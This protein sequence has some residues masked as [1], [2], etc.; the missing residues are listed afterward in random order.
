MATRIPTLFPLANPRLAPFSTTLT[1]GYL[2]RI[3]SMEPSVEPL[4]DTI[5]SH[6]TVLLSWTSESKQSVMTF[7][8]FQ[9]MITMDSF[10]ASDRALDARLG[11]YKVQGFTNYFPPVDRE[12]LCQIGATSSSCRDLTRH[13]NHCSRGG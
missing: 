1:V 2:L 6:S 8:S 5:T 3:N 7:R 11:G 9:Q 4:S 10:M 13:A 12:C